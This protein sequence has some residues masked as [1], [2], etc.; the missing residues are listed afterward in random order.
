MSDNDAEHAKFMR[1]AIDE[2]RRGGEAGNLAVGSVIVRD[3]TVIG[4][5][6]NTAV[7]EGDPTNHA[8]IVAIR[9][10]CG[11]LASAQLT[12]ATLYTAMEPCPMCAWAICMVGIKRLVLGAR[13][14]TFHRPEMGAYAIERLVEMT[15]AKLEVVSGV[16]EVECEALRPELTRR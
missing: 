6:Y 11:T 2:G 12:G 16:L 14:A 13:H 7:S 1:L 10:A 5:G 9:H 15:G 4:R 3:G 8:E